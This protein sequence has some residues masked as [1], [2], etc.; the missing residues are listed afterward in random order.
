MEE[1]GR[2]AV[3]DKLVVSGGTPLEGKVEVSGAK[4]AVL[5]ILAATLL[6]DEPCVIDG[7]LASGRTYHDHGHYVAPWIKMLIAARQTAEEPA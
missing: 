5:P 1:R 3:V 2:E 6:T 4:N 7:N